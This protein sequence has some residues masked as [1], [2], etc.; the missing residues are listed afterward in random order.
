MPQKRKHVMIEVEIVKLP[1]P[2]SKRIKLF[3][4]GNNN[5]GELGLGYDVEEMKYP[6][7]VESLADFNIIKI[8][9]GSLHMAAL[10]RDG[11]VITWGAL[12]RVTK[13]KDPNATDKNVPA[14]AQGL[15]DM[16]IVKVV[17]GS[18]ITLTL[19]EKG[20]NKQSMFVNYGP[21]S[22]LKITDITVGENHVLVLTTNG[23]LYTFGC[24]DSYQLGR[25]ISIRKPNGL[26]LTPVKILSRIKMIFA[27]GNH[28]FAID[29]NGIIYAWGQNMDGQCGILL[30]NPIIT[31]MKLEFF[32]NSIRVNQISMG[33]HHTLVLLENGE[34]YSFSS[35]EYGQLGIGVSEG[36][37]KSPL[38]ATGDHHSMAV[39]DE[40]KVYTWGFGETYALGNQSKN[41]ELLLVKINCEEFEEII[42]V[43]GGSQYSVI[44]SS[45]RS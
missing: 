14:F 35:T 30:P 19:S 42:E 39:N 40:N 20:I 6:R 31:P 9:C 11:K 22:H 2:D 44:L 24:M 43:G 17:C 29:E 16:V 27:R 32:K 15:D 41:D 7:H 45:Y 13:S 1:T 23:Y 8:S 36:N 34:V 5:C 21:T 33:L 26:M 28:S 10:T 25:R 37:R 38:I 3:T 12:G 4:L 18:N